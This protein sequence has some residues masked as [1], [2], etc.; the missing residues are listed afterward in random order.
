MFAIPSSYRAL[1]LKTS[2]DHFNIMIVYNLLCDH[3]HEFEAWFASSSAYEKQVAGGE[4]S[5]PVCSSHKVEKAVMAPALSGAKK[6]NL[7]AGE[8]RQMRQALA[9]MRKKVME[10]GENVGERFPQE[11]RAIHYGDSE[12]RQI[13]GEATLEEAADLAEE[14]IDVMPLPPDIDEIAN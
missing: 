6:S 4:V 7:N 3:G 8:I 1:A 14:G 12:M 11:A 10:T 9:E 5:C 13:Y 2:K